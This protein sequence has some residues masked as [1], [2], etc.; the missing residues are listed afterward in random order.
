MPSNISTPSENAAAAALKLVDSAPESGDEIVTD[1]S[2]TT[3]P[4]PLEGDREGDSDSRR[5]PLWM[6]V[7][8]LILGVVVIGWQAQLASELEAEVAGLERQIDRSQALIEAQGAHLGEI[9]G[10]VYELSDQL[11]GLRALIDAGPHRGAVELPESTPASPT[12]P[13]TP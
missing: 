2:S 4:M 1:T 9:R 6:L 10:G 7:V 13:T 3:A 5:V 11:D 8:A 12:T